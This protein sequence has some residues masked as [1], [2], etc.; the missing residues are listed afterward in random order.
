MEEKENTDLDTSNEEETSESSS[1]DEEIV[2]AVSDKDFFKTLSCLKNKDPSIYDQNIKFFPESLKNEA[3]KR[4][5]EDSEKSIFVKDYVVGVVDEESGDES[6]FSKPLTY[7]E[8]QEATKRFF[9]NELNSDSGS[10]EENGEALMKIKVKNEKAK[11]EEEADYIQ[12]LKGV[13]S[14]L[15]NKEEEKEL[16]PLCEFWNNKNLDEN[17]QFLKDYILNRRY[18]TEESTTLPLNE[19][20]SEDE[21]ELEEQAEFEDRY[22][23]RF[24][25]EENLQIKRFPRQV[26]GSLR[27]KDDSRKKK[28]AEIAQRKKEEKT[29]KHQEIKKKQKEKLVEIEERI[30]KLKEL[31]GNPELGFKDE[32][33][34]EDFDAEKHDQKMKE[35]FNEEFYNQEEEEHPGFNEDDYNW[36]YDDINMDCEADNAGEESKKLTRT[37]KKKLKKKKGFSDI[38]E[39]AKP[40]FDPNVHNNFKEYFDEYYNLDC[41]DF[42]DDIPCKFKY[43]EVVPNDYG[44]SVEEILMADDSEL[45]KWVSVKK[46]CKRRPEHVEKNE[47]KIYSMKAKDE[48]FKKKIFFSLY[49]ENKDD[50]LQDNYTS[51]IKPTAES[52]NMNSK[53]KKKKSKQALGTQENIESQEPM[54]NEKQKKNGENFRDNQYEPNNISEKVEIFS[55]PERKRK[56]D[57]KDE[58][59]MSSLINSENE[60][61]VNDVTTTDDYLIP[62][63]ISNEFSEGQ[64]SLLRNSAKKKAKK[65]KIDQLSLQLGNDIFNGEEG[66]TNLT[67]Q[68]DS[69]QKSVNMKENAKSQEHLTRFP[70]KKR[71]KKKSGQ[72]DVNKSS[73]QENTKTDVTRNRN[74]DGRSGNARNGKKNFKGGFKQRKPKDITDLSDNRLLAYGLKPKQFRAKMKYSKKNNAS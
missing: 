5:K 73:S 63:K 57:C 16:K 40:S 45:N 39:V 60:I 72:Q 9:K 13:K 46:I 34:L 58:D 7:V 30:Q 41:E 32:E 11:E 62:E 70:K 48:N 35:F 65:Q 26:E 18:L 6:E 12:F 51:D 25:T 64:D 53:K 28:R 19:N 33:I 52:S 37:K 20:L 10:D 69:K 21:R 68:E 14:E 74:H 36:D 8:E 44:L 56:R 15:G 4:K 49:S 47:V 27:R 29:K 2:D 61:N 3:K 31:T 17:E 66:N 42:I 55:K 38:M 23:R 71:K 59:E 54:N 22:N 50:S 43:R 67:A 24:E 1:D